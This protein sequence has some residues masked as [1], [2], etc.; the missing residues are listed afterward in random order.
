MRYPDTWAPAEDVHAFPVASR[1]RWK[2]RGA[3][4]G[5]FRRVSLIAAA[6]FYGLAGK[7]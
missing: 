5:I 1:L 3:E 6:G 4:P 7:R 2:Q